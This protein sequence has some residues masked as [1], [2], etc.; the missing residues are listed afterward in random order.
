MVKPIIPNEEDVQIILD[1]L[2]TYPMWHEEAKLIAHGLTGVGIGS[3]DRARYYYEQ[4]IEKLNEVI[5][6]KDM[7]IASK[8]KEI[9]D[10]YDKVQFLLSQLTAIRDETYVSVDLKYTTKGN[11]VPEDVEDKP[12]ITPDTVKGKK[13]STIKRPADNQ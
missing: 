10:L 8:E 4:E 7:V 1:K 2:G 13:K 5:A 3:L 11:P 6:D 12:L 9:A